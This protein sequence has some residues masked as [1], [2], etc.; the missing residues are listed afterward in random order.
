MGETLHTEFGKGKVTTHPSVLPFQ[1]LP[2]LT[3]P[4]LT[5]ELQQ[6]KCTVNNMQ[7]GVERVLTSTLQKA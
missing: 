1:K 7:T 2:R 4:E 3:S 6:L 5:R